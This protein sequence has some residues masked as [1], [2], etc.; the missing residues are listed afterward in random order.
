MRWLSSHSSCTTNSAAAP[1]PT[2]PGTF[3]VPLRNPC[4]CPPPSSCGTRVTRGFFF[5]QTTPPDTFGPYGVLMRRYGTGQRRVR[6]LLPEVCQW[7]RGITEEERAAFGQV[8]P[9][10]LNGVGRRSRVRQH[11]RDQ[12]RVVAQCGNGAAQ[13]PVVRPADQTGDPAHPARDVRRR[14]VPPGARWYR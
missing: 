12:D 11:D 8:P 1:S 6:S 14:R 4:L 9:V 7:L 2:I 13:D 10:P 5:G 3:S